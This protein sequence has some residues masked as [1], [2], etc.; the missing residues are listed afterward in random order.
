MVLTPLGNRRYAVTLENVPAGQS[1]TV[2][3]TNVKGSVVMKRQIQQRTTLGFSPQLAAGM[4]YLK[5][6]CGPQ[7]FGRHL[8]L[9][10]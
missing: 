5:V 4:Y 7:S 2:L 1:A 3:V 6:S 9:M 10:K 8:L